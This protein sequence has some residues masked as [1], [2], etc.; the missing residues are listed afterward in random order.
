VEA[1]I[2]SL[3]GRKC[4]LLLFEGILS[5]AWISVDRRGEGGGDVG[6]VDLDLKIEMHGPTLF[7]SRRRRRRRQQQ[8]DNEAFDEHHPKARSTPSAR[9][10]RRQQRKRGWLPNCVRHPELPR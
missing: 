10:V 6:R 7:F 2:F 5:L 4:R 3:A 1:A 8:T 9:R